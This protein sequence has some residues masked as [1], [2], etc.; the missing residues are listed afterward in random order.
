MLLTH[1][2]AVEGVAAV[3]IES[4]RIEGDQVERIIDHSMIWCAS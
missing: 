3:L 2:E 1:W 4:R